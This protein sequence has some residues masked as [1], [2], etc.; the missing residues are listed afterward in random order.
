MCAKNVRK[1]ALIISSYF[2]T[3]LC[4]RVLDIAKIQLTK[5]SLFELVLG[6]RVAIVTSWDELSST[7]LRQL[8]CKC[9]LSCVSMFK[10]GSDTVCSFTP[11]KK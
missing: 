6:L 5:P 2:T 3:I 7:R 9:I 1:K 8:D 10:F 4:G 11:V